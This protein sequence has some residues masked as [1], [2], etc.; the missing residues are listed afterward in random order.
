MALVAKSNFQVEMLQGTP[1]HLVDSIINEWYGEI[2][3]F[4]VAVIDI[5]R[6][7]GVPCGYRS[8]E[9]RQFFRI[10]ILNQFRNKNFS[11]FLDALP[12]TFS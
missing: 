1:Y 5:V 2:E 6:L 4:I 7:V 10:A 9:F 3:C 12:F 11:C 8:P